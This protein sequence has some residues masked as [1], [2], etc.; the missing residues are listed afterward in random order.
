MSLPGPLRE[1]WKDMYKLH[2]EFDGM[3]NGV[4]DWTAW[5]RTAV[6]VI[7]KHNDSKLAEE[8]VMAIAG[9]LESERKGKR[10]ECEETA[11]QSSQNMQSESRQPSQLT[12]F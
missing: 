2:E 5:W 1:I 8:L 10:E 4:E 3:G 12:L 11:G 6:S 7:H 9:Y